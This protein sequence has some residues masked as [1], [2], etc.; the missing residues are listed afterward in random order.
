MKTYTFS[1]TSNHITV[2]ANSETEARR[3]AMIEKY[4]E[5]PDSIIPHAPN[6]SGH[7]L[8]LIS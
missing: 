2:K 1:S 8:I 6:Y 4:G 3:L 7:G 5:K